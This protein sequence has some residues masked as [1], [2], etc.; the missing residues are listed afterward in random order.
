[1]FLI[2]WLFRIEKDKG[3]IGNEIGDVRAATEEVVRSKAS[4]EK[5]HR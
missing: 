5:S 4:A 1:M 2:L 3:Q